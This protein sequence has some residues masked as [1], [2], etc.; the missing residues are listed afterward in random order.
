MTV[1]HRGTRRRWTILTAIAVLAADAF[2]LVMFLA[3]APVERLSDAGLVVTP[4]GQSSAEAAYAY[5][6]QWRH[7]MAG[8]S[9]LYMPGFFAAA[10]AL[11]FWSMGKTLRRV[12]L[13]RTALL[14]AG[15]LLA[16]LL[17]PPLSRTAL[18][19]FQADTG[20]VLTG[21]QE[22]SLGV[23]SFQGAYTLIAWST[24]V[25]GSRL[26]I[27]RRTLWPLSVAVVANVILALVRPW[28]MDDFS[29]YWWRKTVAGDPIAVVS[30]GLV[31]VMATV[32][33]LTELARER[34]APRCVY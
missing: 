24:V 12:V 19:S 4:S 29:E 7:G 32:L 6:A 18:R 3:A 8:N 16:F 2:F 22:S 27:Q 26:A 30:S 21:F 14:A 23:A 1:P 20:A 17:A 9:P 25:I 5:A 33:A 11:W 10:A 13:E 28:T 15:L 34:R 31:F